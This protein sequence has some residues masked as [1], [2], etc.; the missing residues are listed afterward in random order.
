MTFR[1]D[2]L[3]YFFAVVE[4]GSITAAAQAI[5]LAQPALSTHVKALEEDL[6]VRLFERS[7]RGVTLTLA[8]RKLYDRGASVLRQV[9]QLYEEIVQPGEEPVGEVKVAIAASVAPLLSGY[10]FWRA[11]EKYPGIDL[12]MKD[13]S[14]VL[15]KNRI[16]SGEV[17]LALLPNIGAV[18]NVASEPLVSQRF[19]LV[20]KSFPGEMQDVVTLKELR[21]FPLVMGSR[22]NQFRIALEDI[23]L[24]EGCSLN[25]VSEQETIPVYGSIISSGPAYT[26][27][28]Y[29][30]FSEEIESG[31]LQAKEIVKPAVERV[32]SMA[33]REDYELSAAANAAKNLLRTCVRELVVQ[34]KLVGRELRN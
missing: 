5:N 12:K 1:F 9:E 17:D 18:P 23:A 31:R 3:R 8:G 34:G 21:R 19:F 32:L 10:F 25:I 33:W 11:K 22:R 24:R 30:A 16:A 4:H 28:P 26:V 29:S 27:V 7:V 13:V 20:G 2:R 6:G 14:N 15:E